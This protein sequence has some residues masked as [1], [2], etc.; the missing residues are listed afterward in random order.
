MI[1]AIILTKNEEKN[2]VD[3]LESLYFCD[4]KI[5]IDDYSSDRTCEIAK[6][7]KVKV[8]KRKL[9]DDFAAQRNFGISEAK[10]EWILFVDADE[11]I[12]KNLQT[13]ILNFTSNT[14]SNGV[15]IKRSD[16]LWGKKLKHGE[17]GSIK[18]LRLA[19]KD[20]GKWFGKVHEKWEIEG[21][22]ATLKNSIYHFPHQTIYDFMSEI[23]KYTTIKANELY[24]IGVK[25][26]W[27]EILFYPKAKFFQNFFLKLGFLDGLEGFVFAIIMSFH[28]FLVR[29]KLWILNQKN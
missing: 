26:R 14:N 17:V 22:K 2:I 19:R 15:F 11:R 6:K 25:V 9:N 23:N 29:G 8:F 20:R 21:K 5:I 24:S 10:G 3:C 4:E 28:S 7:F 1:T 18:F 12:P 13:E 16:F 27:Y